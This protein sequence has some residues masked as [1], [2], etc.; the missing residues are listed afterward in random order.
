MPEMDGYEVCRQLKDNP[1]TQDIPVIFVTAKGEVEDET[2]GLG[3]GAVDYITKPFN[4][5]IVKARVKTHL[6]LKRKSD[7]L[8]RF[9][10]IDGLTEIP[11]RRRFNEKFRTEWSRNT[12]SETR[13]SVIIMDIDYF[14]MYNDHYG[15][16]AGDDCLKAVAQTLQK[17]TKRAGDLVARYGGEEFVA[18]LPGCAADDAVRLA[19]IFLSEI[20]KLNVPHA[21]SAVSDHVTLSAGAAT[22]VPCGSPSKATLVEAADRMLYEAKRN[23][24][25][26]VKGTQ[27]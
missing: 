5:P 8:E 6:R 25:N 27:Y 16:A 23:G 15:H 10:F 12:R 26:Q 20:E 14:K 3:L 9:A 22:T 18:I 11:N 21:R 17:S 13:L 2:S 1:T 4:V 7:M 24:R 19:G